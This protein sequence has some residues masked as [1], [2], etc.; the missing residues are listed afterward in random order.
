MKINL[1]HKLQRNAFMRLFPFFNKR[2]LGD[3]SNAKEF[4][5]S[6][7]DVRR[8][9]SISYSATIFDT[10]HG[11]LLFQMVSIKASSHFNFSSFFFF[12]SL[13]QR[14]TVS[15]LYSSFCSVVLP[16]TLSKEN[17]LQTTRPLLHVKQIRL[18]T[19]NVIQT[20]RI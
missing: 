10:R 4:I 14:R 9:L 15:Q 5:T 2:V 11:Q 17:N 3:L 19:S 1:P 12:S 6:F 7:S 16:I 8:I 13:M 20:K 18:Q